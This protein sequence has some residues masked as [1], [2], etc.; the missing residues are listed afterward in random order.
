MKLTINVTDIAQWEDF[1]I[2]SE[3]ANEC[4]KAHVEHALLSNVN[5]TCVQR[6]QSYN[7][8]VDVQ[9][10]RDTFDFC[11]NVVD[12]DSEDY[13]SVR[14]GLEVTLNETTGLEYGVSFSIDDLGSGNYQVVMTQTEETV[15]A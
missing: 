4:F 7:S 8:P 14:E 11:I 1:D 15:F 12:G 3:Q 13:D 10:D 9:Y 2:D 5:V 6:D